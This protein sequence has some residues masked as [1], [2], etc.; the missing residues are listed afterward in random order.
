MVRFLDE[1]I[2]ASVNLDIVVLIIHT[3]PKPALFREETSAG[4]DSKVTVID[5]ST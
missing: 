4:F 2:T 5:Q 1:A 3:K